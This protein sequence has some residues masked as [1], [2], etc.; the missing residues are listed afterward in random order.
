[1]G[2]T[3]TPA[4]MSAANMIF[5]ENTLTKSAE[6]VGCFEQAQVKCA[7]WLTRD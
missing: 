1:M 4:A 7:I 3:I 5:A 6:M 2:V